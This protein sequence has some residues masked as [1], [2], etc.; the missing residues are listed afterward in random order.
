MKPSVRLLS[1]A[2]TFFSVLISINYYSLSSSAVVQQRIVND[3]N[4]CAGLQVIAN[5]IYKK[6]QITFQG[7]EGLPINTNVYEHNKGTDRLCQ[8]GYSTEISPMGKQVCKGYI[9][10]NTESPQLSSGIGYY[11]NSLFS[12]IN[13]EADF[14]RYVD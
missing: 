8:L 14:C 13:R 7:F 9:Y 12:P 4:S 3:E 5:R 10:T 1:T 2:I 6:H 11:R